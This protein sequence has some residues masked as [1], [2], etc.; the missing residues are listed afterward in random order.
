MADNRVMMMNPKDMDP[1][2]LAYWEMERQE[3]MCRK[4]AEFLASMAGGAEDDT[5]PPPMPDQEP[6]MM[7]S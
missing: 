6:A 2:A 4:K 3:I 5:P 1:L 7:A